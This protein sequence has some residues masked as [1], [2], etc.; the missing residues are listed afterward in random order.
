MS[1]SY[2][3]IRRSTERL[4]SIG[5][6]KQQ[7]MAEVGFEPI[8]IVIISNKQMTNRLGKELKGGES[9]AGTSGWLGVLAA[10]PDTLASVPGI[11]MVERGLTP[12]AGV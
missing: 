12:N 4:E 8:I 1:I 7:Q 3:P 11:H 2:L 9:A 6:S 10:E 5:R